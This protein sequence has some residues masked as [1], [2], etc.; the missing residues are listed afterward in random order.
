MIRRSI[1]T[2][3]GGPTPGGRA[4]ARSALRTPIIGPIR[5]STRAPSRR[6]LSPVLGRAAPRQGVASADLSRDWASFPP[7]NLPTTAW[8]QR[9]PPA[10]STPQTDLTT[11]PAWP[12]PQSPFASLGQP[13]A[14]APR[15][16]STISVACS[17]MTRRSPSDCFRTRSDRTQVQRRRSE[18]DFVCRRSDRVGADA[19]HARRLACAGMGGIVP[20]TARAIRLPSGAA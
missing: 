6:P 5:S 3:R 20:R 14:Q 4:L 11:A 7:S 10:F 16:R 15:G 8:P 19:G 17:R 2:T 9:V 13:A 18:A 12:D 1:Q